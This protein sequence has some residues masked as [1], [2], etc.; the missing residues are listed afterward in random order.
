[1]HET[2]DASILE[3]GGR[4]RRSHVMIEH[5][6]P[7]A[8]R[9]AEKGRLYLDLLRRDLADDPDDIDRLTFLAAEHHKLGEFGAATEVAERLAGLLPDDFGA[10]FTVALYH[11]AY[12]GDRARARRSVQTALRI[13][14]ADAE[15]LELHAQLAA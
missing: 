5:H 14:P 13:R 9:E 2:I 4:L 1:V 10:H 8:E 6:L 15:A 12:G 11:F 7:S 3:A